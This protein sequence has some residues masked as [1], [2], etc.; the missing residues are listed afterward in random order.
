MN[1]FLSKHTSFGSVGRGYVSLSFDILFHIQLPTLYKSNHGSTAIFHLCIW[2][3]GQNHGLQRWN[4]RLDWRDRV[5]SA[6]PSFTSIVMCIGQ[7]WSMISFL[8]FFFNGK[9]RSCTLINALYNSLGIITLIYG[10]IFETP[11]FLKGNVHGK[12]IYRNPL[13]VFGQQKTNCVLRHAA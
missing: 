11:A 2:L 12:N 9:H 7:A 6:D 4:Q 3:P 8:G 13:F 5:G 1:S 10:I